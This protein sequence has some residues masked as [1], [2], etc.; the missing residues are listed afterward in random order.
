MMKGI[1]IGALGAVAM[2]LAA[3]Y[4]VAASGRIPANADARPPALEKWVA[5]RALD[6]A[7]LREAPRGPNPVALTDA[8]LVAGIRLYAADCAVC[9]G[10][11]DAAPS[12]I[13]SGLYQK[14]P[15]LAKYGVEDDDEGDTYWKL[16]HGIRMT[17]MPSFRESLTEDELWKIALFL[18]NM[19]SLPPGP[20]KVWDAVPSFAGSSPAKL[21]T[22]RGN[23]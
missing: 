18:K 4:L 21:V 20:Q 19:D 2:G 10:A 7:I 23:K 22:M 3:F 1:V 6:A 13:G 16:Y 9:H 15:L 17:G 11:A 12:P 14:A 5:E 8:N